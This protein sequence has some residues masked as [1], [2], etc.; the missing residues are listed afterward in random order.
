MLC[1]YIN[2]D[3]SNEKWFEIDL[4]TLRGPKGVN[5][6][7]NQDFN[8]LVTISG[9]K[10]FNVTNDLDFIWLIVLKGVKGMSMN[11]NRDSVFELVALK[12]ISLP[13]G[14]LKALVYL[15]IRILID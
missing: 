14:V 11:D 3:I 15:L 5:L 7:N 9:A 12:L 4:F 2:C 8:W 10:D 6:S 13:W 1:I